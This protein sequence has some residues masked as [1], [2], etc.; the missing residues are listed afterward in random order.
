LETGLFRHADTSAPSGT[1]HYALVLLSDEQRSRPI[2]ASVFVTPAR[3]VSPPENFTATAEP[4]AIRL[5]WD[6]PDDAQLRY[7]IS[8]APADAGEFAQLNAAPLRSRFYVDHHAVSGVAY[9]YRVSSLTRRNLESGPAPG[10]KLAALPEPREPV[11]IAM[12][13]RDAAGD[14][15]NERLNAR[16]NGKARVRNA[17]LDLREGGSATF[18][19]QDAFELRTRFSVECRIRPSRTDRMPVLLSHGHWNENGW[20]L[21]M[22]NGVW[23][24]HVGGIDCDGGTA[25]ADKWTHLV[26][27]FD[28]D[29]AQ[30]F[31]DGKLVASVSGEANRMPWSRPFIIGQYGASPG[32]EYQVHGQ[33]AGVKIYHRALKAEEAAAGFQE[34]RASR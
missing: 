21:Q 33:I 23:R 32:P 14:M 29:R 11:F 19:P 27:T 6:A 1:Q 7:N 28:G 34:E 26:A 25:V 31:Q 10:V 17:A 16:V 22:L 8:R 3:P 5:T 2:R 9:E 12:F 20:F 4:G 18:P 13:E 15:G 30:L 24:W